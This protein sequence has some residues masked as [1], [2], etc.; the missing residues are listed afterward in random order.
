M[1]FSSF[2]FHS[3]SFAFKDAQAHF[4]FMLSLQKDVLEGRG[5]RIAA[6][7][8]NINQSTSAITKEKL[9]DL[10]SLYLMAEQKDKVGIM[11]NLMTVRGLADAVKLAKSQ[12]A[13][14]QVAA[15]IFRR[16]KL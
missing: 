6:Y 13:E 11:Q 12:C 1:S 4:N 14:K 2:A 5:D 7:V 10:T 8:D 16:S 3:R 9:A 15:P